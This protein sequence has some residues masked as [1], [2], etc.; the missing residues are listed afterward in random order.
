[1]KPAA[2]FLRLATLVVSFGVTSLSAQ[3]SDP[4]DEPAGST[5]GPVY[6]GTLAISSPT[7]SGGNT[8]VTGL[9]LAPDAT[10][11][12]PVNFS[13]VSL[14]NGSIVPAMAGGYTGATVV[15]NPTTSTNLVGGGSTATWFGGDRT[16]TTN[17]LSTSG[18]TLTLSSG[19][20]NAT[21][22]LGAWTGATLTTG[23]DNSTNVLSTSGSTLTLASGTTAIP[24]TSGASTGATLTITGSTTPTNVLINGGA[25]TLTLANSTNTTSSSGSLVLGS[26][27]II[28]GI[29]STAGTLT[30]S[31]TGASALTGGTVLVTTQNIAAG[32]TLSRPLTISS[33]TVSLQNATTLNSSLQLQNNATLSVNLGNGAAGSGGSITVAGDVVLSGNLAVAAPANLPVG[34]SFVILNKTSAGIIAGRFSG[35]PQGSIISLSGNDFVISYTGGDGNDVTLT[36]LSKAQAWRQAHFGTVEETGAA[37]DT[38]DADADGIPNLIERACLLD[39][40][41]SSTLPVST[42]RSGA[43]L[44][45]NY[46][47]SVAAVNAG[48]LFTVEWSDSLTAAT[49]S[50]IGV[51]QEVQSDDGT[52][53]IVKATVPAGSKGQRFIRLKITPAP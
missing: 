24:A 20:T 35:Q 51:T 21:I 44:E 34:S 12:A 11:W 29:N 1:M 31:Q 19:N 52:I 43:S 47:R 46:Q 18:S 26:P 32:G 39:P 28:N 30:L 49:W 48:D 33:G 40:A 9:A 45:Y 36:A 25:G 50:S 37:A 15:A 13:G 22:S 27:V 41:A 5:G 10:L 6:G 14:A 2:R 4:V 16:L 7:W 42:A 17:V 23:V 38:A 3:T 53:Q 8:L